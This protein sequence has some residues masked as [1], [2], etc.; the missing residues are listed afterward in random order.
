MTLHVPIFTILKPVEAVPSIATT[1]QSSAG[2]N[3]VLSSEG[4]RG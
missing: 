1:S 2:S 4:S 3:L